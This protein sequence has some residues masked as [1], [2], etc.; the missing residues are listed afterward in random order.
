MASTGGFGHG[1]CVFWELGSSS[2]SED[3]VQL[4]A[5]APAYE[6]EDI[7]TFL[8]DPF[9]KSSKAA[10]FDSL[11]QLLSEDKPDVLVV[12]T[13][14][15]QIPQA[16]KKGIKAGCH[17]IVEKPIALSPDKA[18]YLEN[19]AREYKVHVMAQLSM[20]EL[21]AFAKAREWVKEGRI[22]KPVLINARKS[23]RWGQRP[24]WFADRK[25]YG[26]TWPWVGIHALDMV[27]F[28]TGLRVKSVS[29]WHGN[30]AHPEMPECEDVCTGTFLLTGDIPLNV[31]VDLCRPASAP[32][33]G[34]DWIR[35]VGT[36]GILEANASRPSCELIEEGHQPVLA[37]L[38]SE[39][40]PLYIPFLKSLSSQKSFDDTAFYLT[41][42]SLAARDSADSG[43]T[44]NLAACQAN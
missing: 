43:K 44:V 11:D 27:D 10:V 29:A 9:V 21:P 20:H 28:I 5:L 38:S 26:G 24:F 4:T 3:L 7:S 41:Q 2:E 22:G 19:L 42:A 33:H 37:E 8:A 23:Y 35:I 25:L 14:P 17:L 6:G 13:R 16:V 15:D 12:S 34:D 18:A 1:V 30:R 39:N 36:K 31:S 32:S 40:V